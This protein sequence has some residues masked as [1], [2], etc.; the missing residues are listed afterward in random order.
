[1]EVVDA[2]EGSSAKFE[3][4]EGECQGLFARSTGGGTSSLVKCSRAG[5]VEVH[6]NNGD[7]RLEGWERKS[8]SELGGPLDC[9]SLTEEGH[10]L[11]VGGRGRQ[12]ALHDMGASLVLSPYFPFSQNGVGRLRMDWHWLGKQSRGGG[13]SAGRPS[14]RIVLAGL[15]GLTL[16]PFASSTAIGSSSQEVL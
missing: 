6:Y 7:S 3:K 9:C 5:R 10:F 15:K 8:Q 13:Y 2:E 16:P 4:S 14:R 11:A 1:M 12:L